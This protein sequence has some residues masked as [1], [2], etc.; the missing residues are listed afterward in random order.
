MRL[1]AGVPPA[2]ADKSLLRQEWYAAAGCG[3]TTRT[4]GAL[5]EMSSWALSPPPPP[6]LLKNMR[7]V[8]FQCHTFIN[9]VNTLIPG[10]I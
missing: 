9:I 7:L 3:E 2:P 10:F 4:V 1:L 5:R 6:C 8:S